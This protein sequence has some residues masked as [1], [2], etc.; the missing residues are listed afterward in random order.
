L[1]DPAAVQS[2]PRDDEGWKIEVAPI[3]AW[4]PLS[5]SSVTL[6]TFPDLPLPPGGGDRP[7]AD[8]D[9]GLNGAAMAAIRIE[10]QRWM[11]RANVVW[12]GLSGEAERPRAR[13]SGN[14]IYGEAL[15]GV[16]VARGLWIEGGVRR[17]AVD[18]EAEVLD[19]PKVSRKPGVWD[20]VVGASLRLPLGRKWL[21]TLHGDGGGFGVGSEVDVN[22]YATLDWRMAEHFGLTL[23]YSVL[24]FRLED[25]WTEGTRLEQ[26]LKLGT[27]LAGPI[28]GIK[29]LF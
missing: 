7:S 12:A 27:T 25:D 26:T 14:L 19:Y 22:G 8:T 23:G 9:A 20:P 13:V 3:Y 16:K 17:L 10:K 1:Q 29:L 5:I 21:L 24:Y 6:P 2:A 18:L 4:V 28:V 15:T 11:L